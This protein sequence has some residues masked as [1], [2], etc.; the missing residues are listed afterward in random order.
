[1]IR[2]NVSKQPCICVW[3]VNETL[4]FTFASEDFISYSVSVN[5]SNFHADIVAIALEEIIDLNASNIMKARLVC[6]ASPL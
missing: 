6:F 1:M 4:S 5:E 3:Y 2:N